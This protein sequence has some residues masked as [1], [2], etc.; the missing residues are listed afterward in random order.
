MHARLFPIFLVSLL[1]AGCQDQGGGPVKPPV[2][3]CDDP[4]QLKLS[5]PAVTSHKVPVPVKG[6]PAAI[7]GM[8]W[9]RGDSVL[10]FFRGKDV[11]LAFTLNRELYLVA[12]VGGEP[13]L[14]R[15]SHGDE[16]VNGQVGSINSPLFSP[17]GRKIVYPGTIQGKPV[18]I[19]DAVSGDQVT[20]RV[21]IDPKAHVT[22]DPHWFV[23]GGKTWI[24][25]ATLSNLVRYS[26]ICGQVEG[27]TY[28]M[29]LLDDTTLSSI[30]PTGVPGAYRGGI[31]KDGKW[32]GTSYA[33]TTLF[34][35][36]ADTT[37]VLAGKDNQQ[38]NPSMNPY[39]P[40][41]KHM[42][43][44]MV[45]GFGGVP[46]Q[47]ID[48]SVLN[49]GSHE[50]LWIFNR[51]DKVV[52]VAKRPDTVYYKNW[53]KPEWSTHP[54]FATAVAIY[55]S[56]DTEGDLFVVN[57]GDLADLDEGKLHEPKAFLRIA[58]GGFT[59]DSFSHLWV[60]E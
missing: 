30:Q 1:L 43:Y 36:E 25:F 35:V 47:G 40:G 8:T 55:A 20:W 31:S 12:Y 4:L 56:R 52:W 6:Q 23:E 17:D 24:Y 19:R 16:G 10:S 34:D 3:Q 22:A 48:G 58:E 54:E 9:A 7:A 29:E 42:D 26:E 38:C 51:N 59:S 33:T 14:T 49:E 50:K 32:T 57:I 41:S 46:Y 37:L 5:R 28:K 53:D 60:A 13:S 18:F 44:L 21:P 15:I 39:P 11:K 45:L 27:N 2:P